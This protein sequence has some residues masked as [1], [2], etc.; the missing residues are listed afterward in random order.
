MSRRAGFVTTSNSSSY[1]MKESAT[2]CYNDPYCV[3]PHPQAI[4]TPPPENNVGD[5]LSPKQS[6]G[7]LLQT[8]W[9]YCNN[10]LYNFLRV[11]FFVTE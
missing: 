10:L 9:K 6:E 8:A 11:Q 5:L 2:N 4:P 3:P 1:Q 7:E